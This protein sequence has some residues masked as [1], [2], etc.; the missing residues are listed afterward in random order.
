MKMTLYFLTAL[1]LTP[2]VCADITRIH[3]AQPRIA[4]RQVRD[5]AVSREKTYVPVL[6]QWGI[7]RDD[8][9]MA[10][11]PEVHAQWHR[12]M[13]LPTFNMAVRSGQW[14]ALKLDQP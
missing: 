2:W 6:Q 9:N 7:A 5:G 4:K 1:W 8:W 10:P 11:V 13:R 12:R 14:K 3:G